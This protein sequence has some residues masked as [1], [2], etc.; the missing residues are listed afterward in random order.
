MKKVLIYLVLV[1]Y[2]TVLVR[3]AVPFVA[4]VIAHTFWYAH[5]VATVHFENGRYHVHYQYMKEAQKSFPGKNQQQAKTEVFI[6]DHLLGNRKFDL[7]FFL[8]DKKYFEDLSFS[9][10]QVNPFQHYPPPKG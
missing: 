8:I 10:P 1:S 4:D 2:T 3:P 7:V 6:A 9:I 5:H